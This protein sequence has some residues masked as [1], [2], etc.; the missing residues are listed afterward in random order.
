MGVLDGFKE[1]LNVSYQN[2][3]YKTALASGEYYK[4][5]MHEDRIIDA[6]VVEDLIYDVKLDIKDQGEEILSKILVKFM[7]KSEFSEQIGNLIKSD[8][9]V[10]NMNLPPIKLISGRYYVKN[11]SLYHLMKEKQVVFFTTIEGDIIR[12]LIT[13]FTEYDIMVSL[14]GGIPVTIFRHSIHDVRNKQGRC[15]LKSFQQKQKDWKKSSLYID[16]DR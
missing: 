7:I 8:N 14:K 11:K 12:G 5:Y 1:Y 6:K 9:K 2:S 15:F 10:K 16:N 13:D 4:F 3:I